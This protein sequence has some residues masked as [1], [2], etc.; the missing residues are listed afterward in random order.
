MLVK[1]FELKLVEIKMN[2][3]FLSNI[4]IGMPLLTL[5]FLKIILYTFL[6]LSKLIKNM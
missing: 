1:T 5:K 3:F 4:F 6:N 2:P